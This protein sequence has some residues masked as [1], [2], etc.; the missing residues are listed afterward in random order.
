[1]RLNWELCQFCPL[2]L[3]SL[4]RNPAVPLITH[5]RADWCS[6]CLGPASAICSSW[7]GLFFFSRWVSPGTP[8]GWW[9]STLAPQYRS[10]FLPILALASSA[11]PPAPSA[12]QQP[13]P[14]PPPKTSAPA[15]R[16]GWGRW[17][18]EETGTR[19][20]AEERREEEEEIST[21][22]HTS[23]DDSLVAEVFL[24]RRNATGR[25]VSKCDFI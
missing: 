20:K 13:E 15:M 4:K 7:S 2:W 14:T 1:M 8:G 23:T 17:C 22:I 19:G 25:Q 11:A 24:V 9:C 5:Q 12:P 21:S 10:L 18:G 6:Y 3:I 16:R